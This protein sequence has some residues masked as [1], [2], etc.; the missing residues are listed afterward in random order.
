MRPGGN[1]GLPSGRGQVEQGPPGRVHVCRE[2]PGGQLRLDDVRN[3][4]RAT[5]TVLPA[6]LA[7]TASIAG[8]GRAHRF[9]Q[10]QMAVLSGPWTALCDWLGIDV[11]WFRR[12]SGLPHHVL[13]GGQ[14][15]IGR[16]KD[17][18]NT[19]A[20]PAEV[21]DGEFLAAGLAEQ[22]GDQPSRSRQSPGT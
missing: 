7:R 10:G 3:P 21:G 6:R 2:V 8:S 17:L 11:T 1:A 9:S 14:S 13:Q 12:R 16:H 15:V 4:S 19:V 22:S 5:T 20:V 18:R